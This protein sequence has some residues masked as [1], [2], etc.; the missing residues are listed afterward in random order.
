[1]NR[2][3][4]ARTAPEGGKKCEVHWV[5]ITSPARGPA[6][7]PE[8]SDQMPPGSETKP[9]DF[10]HLTTIG[11]SRKNAE[12]KLKKK[13]LTEIAGFHNFSRQSSGLKN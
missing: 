4:L 12:E 7:P 5:L 10:Q 3:K 2:S 8:D 6:S 11:F 9:I 1:V 13:P